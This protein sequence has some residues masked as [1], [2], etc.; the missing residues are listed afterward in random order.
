MP[1][2]RNSCINPRQRLQLVVPNSRVH[3]LIHPRPPAEDPLCARRGSRP[4]TQ[5]RR[6]QGVF[7]PHRVTCQGPWPA[8]DTASLWGQR[9]DASSCPGS[10]A[11]P[12]AGADPD[13]P[14]AGGCPAPRVPPGPR[15]PSVGRGRKESRDVGAR[16]LSLWGEFTAP[17]SH[18]GRPR[19][20]FR[21]SRRVTSPLQRS[22]SASS[23]DRHA[24]SSSTLSASVTDRLGRDMEA[25]M[26][27]RAP[28][29]TPGGWT[30]S[31]G[32]VSDGPADP[33]K[34]QR[35]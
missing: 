31:P 10:S 30:W 6:L 13:L 4:E 1:V 24:H 19:R 21:H 7:C 35:L 23:H 18:T 25:G 15:P 34:E 28:V 5:R 8:L 33:R 20:R 11:S 14:Q 32:S 29:G 17:A 2:P 12:A 22:V 3:P 9:R 27:P 26:C 16:A